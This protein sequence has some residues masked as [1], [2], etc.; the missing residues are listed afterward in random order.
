MNEPGQPLPAQA[1]AAPRPSRGIARFLYCQN[2]FYLLSVTFV[3]HG[4]G[5]WYQANAG[6]H[7]TWILIGIITAYILMMAGAGF[8]IVRFGRVWDD[9]RSILLILILLFLE[10]AMTADDVLVD[11]R[12]YDTGR[13]MLLT[14]WLVAAGVSEFLLISL[15]IRMRALYRIPFHLMLAILL[16]YPL[17]IVRGA[18]PHDQAATIW[19][20]FLFSPVASLALLTLVPAIRRG[21][22]YVSENGTPWKW[23]LYPMSL[24]VVVGTAMVFRSYALSLSYDPVLDV[25]WTAALDMASRFG[26]IFVVPFLLALS[27][28]CLEGSRV[29]DG[30]WLRRIGLL[31][32]FLAL[33][34]STPDMSQPTLYLGFVEM[35]TGQY[36]SPVWFTAAASV[37]I[38]GHA[39]IQQTRNAELPLSLM[40]LVLGFVG[41]TTLD[42]TQLAPHNLIPLAAASAI[43]IWAG[44]KRDSA[45][46]LFAGL[47]CGVL[48]TRT[49]LP[50][51]WHWF[52]RDIIT[53]HLATATALVVGIAMKSGLAANLRVI[54]ATM[55]VMSCAGSSFANW[56][57]PLELPELL[58]GLHMVA[59][60]LASLALIG[61]HIPLL[62]WTA[63]INVLATLSAGI[64]KGVLLI[65]RLPGGQGIVWALG[66]LAWFTLAALISARK[67]GLSWRSRNRSE[68]G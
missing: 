13:V 60:A 19:S 50:A 61:C 24:F 28:L 7:S 62:R 39:T 15:G 4:T 65:L 66:G 22:D 40:L 56:M 8:A 46:K 26:G 27:V 34:V 68:S 18:Y 3:L 33:Y 17:A 59:V 6:T 21:A 47:L 29:T 35:M 41:P 37:L 49:L 5:I 63:T 67:A 45:A 43:Q 54:G 36:A 12:L 23:P 16:L 51:D 10:L 38:L 1:E 64:G 14:A 42:I 25:S 53:W 48:L 32:P 9:A 55:L 2:P 30:A 44:W 20:I 11:N 52:L 31:L 57:V 58:L